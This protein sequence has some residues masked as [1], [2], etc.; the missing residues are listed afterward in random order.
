MQN[1]EIWK[2]IP[3]YEGVYQVSIF[4][5]VRS[6]DREIAQNGRKNIFT[7]IM[8]GKILTPRKQNN[9]YCV[10]WLSKNGMVKAYT[11]HKIVMSAFNPI[12]K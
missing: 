3:E 4:G 12:I 1:I 6:L 11:I 9:G 8:R 5:R 2:D 7:R 10:V